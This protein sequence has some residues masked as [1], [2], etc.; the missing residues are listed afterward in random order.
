MLNFTR[1]GNIR[2]KK[3]VNCETE[4]WKC[5]VSLPPWEMWEMRNVEMDISPDPWV[6]FKV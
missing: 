3:C 5:Y 1:A 4:K 2:N 6:K